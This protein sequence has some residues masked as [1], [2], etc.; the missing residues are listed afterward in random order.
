MAGNKNHGFVPTSLRGMGSMK[1]LRSV[2]SK[3]ISPKTNRPKS[4]GK[5]G[6]L[7]IS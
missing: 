4:K 2:N 5:S 7:L 3:P 6:A 1:D